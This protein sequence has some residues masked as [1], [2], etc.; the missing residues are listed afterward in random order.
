MINKNLMKR[1][2]WTKKKHFSK[3]SFP[4]GRAPTRRRR[5]HW[6]A[7]SEGSPSTTPR[8]LGRLSYIFKLQI[9]WK[10]ILLPSD[11]SVNHS[12][13]YLSVHIILLYP[14]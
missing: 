5:R 2:K 1:K 6:T 7:S 3:V 10:L 11:Y 14:I 9:K 8:T 13:T 12:L 4:G